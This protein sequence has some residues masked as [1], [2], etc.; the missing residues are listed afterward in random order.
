M[1]RYD[2]TATMAQ[3]LDRHLVIPLF[4]F[5]QE[6]QV[7]ERHPVARRCCSISFVY[8]FQL[9]DENEVL[10]AKYETLLQTSMVD[11]AI[12]ILDKMSSKDEAARASNNNNKKKQKQNKK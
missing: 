11:L 4:E 3:Y 6:R 9:Y 7:K 12:E 5:L 10:Q 8:R 2:L 1:A